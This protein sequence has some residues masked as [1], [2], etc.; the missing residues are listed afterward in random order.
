MSF[1]DAFGERS[2]RPLRRATFALADGVAG[3]GST[4]SLA[5]REW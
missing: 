5:E 1:G 2:W 4:H 3:P